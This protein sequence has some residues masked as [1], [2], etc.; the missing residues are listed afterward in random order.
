[1]SAYETNLIAQI[2]AKLAA[3]RAIIEKNVQIIAKTTATLETSK[4]VET[5]PE[6]RASY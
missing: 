1:M 5:R 2:D 6:A 3:L 4:R